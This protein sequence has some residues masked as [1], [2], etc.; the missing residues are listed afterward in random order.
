M[1]PTTSNDA[2]MNLLRLMH[3]QDVRT[4]LEHAGG[5]TIAQLRELAALYGMHWRIAPS[6]TSQQPAQLLDFVHHVLGLR[7]YGRHA[8]VAAGLAADGCEV[9]SVYVLENLAADDLIV[10]ADPTTRLGAELLAGTLFDPGAPRPPKTPDRA[11][12]TGADDD[13]RQ[14]IS[15][16][17]GQSARSSS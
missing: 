5:V 3:G 11:I 7:I 14:M 4:R 15:H 1:R 16:F 13:A 8:N 17:L 2:T 9:S 10:V 6:G 12:N